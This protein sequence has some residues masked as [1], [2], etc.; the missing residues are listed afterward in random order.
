MV[1]AS[2]RTEDDQDLPAVPLDSDS[3]NDIEDPES[4]SNRSTYS[5]AYS[6]VLPYVAQLQISPTPSSTCPFSL[7]AGLV[8]GTVHPL[9][10]THHNHPYSK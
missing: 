2:S 7:S 3:D 8:A 6:D 1:E 9:R 4:A 5:S 10:R